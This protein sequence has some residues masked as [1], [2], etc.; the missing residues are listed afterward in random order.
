MGICTSESYSKYNCNHVNFDGEIKDVT[1]DYL[2]EESIKEPLIRKYKITKKR[3]GKG[4]FGSILIA[5]DSSG[6]KY[7]IKLIKKIKIINGQFLLNEVRISK[8]MNHPHILKIKEVYEDKK[9]ILFIMDYIEGGSLFN[10]IK[11]SPDG[12]LSIYTTI[13]ILI[14]ILEA[15]DYLHNKIRICHRDIKPENFLVSM[16]ENKPYVKLID[17]GL[18]FE[19]KKGEKGIGKIGTTI[20]MAPEVLKRVPYNEKIDMW[21]TGVLLFNMSTGCDPFYAENEERKIYYI[22]NTEAEFD[23]IENEYIKDLCKNLMEKNP[24]ERIDA[25]NALIKAKK[26]RKIIYENYH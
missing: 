6:N 20:Y 10:Y 22:L 7:A 25:K 5:V 17:F 23:A 18:A 11:S 14:Q 26:I 24:C 19:I 16:K 8:R 9:N 4:A 12:K 13:D 3:I 21:S 2:L 15:L 1:R